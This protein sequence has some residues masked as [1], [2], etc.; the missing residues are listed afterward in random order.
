MADAVLS[1]LPAGLAARLTPEAAVRSIAV[2]GG[3][4]VFWNAVSYPSIQGYDAASHREYADWLVQHRSLPT[5]PHTPEYY[6][7]PLYYLLA[8]LADAVGRGVGLG[9]PWRLA[10]LLNV[11]AVVGTVLLVAAIARLVWPGRRWLAPVA[12]AFVVLSPVLTRTASMFHPET[13]DLFFSALGAYLALRML[14]RREY[15]LRAALV[16]G[17]ALG[18]GEMVRQFALYTLSVVAAAWLVAAWQRPQE[19]R[20]L[21]RA[22]AAALA[23][24]AVVAGP[25][26]VYRAVHYSNPLFNGVSPSTK[27]YFDR[28]PASFYLGSGLPDLFTKP[29][30]PNMADLAWPQTYADIWGD[31]YGVFS[32]SIQRGKPSPAAN[33]WLVLQNAVG[34]AP[35]AIALAGWLAL[36]GLAVRR[37]AGP[38]LLVALL[39]LA[40]LAGYFYFAI[41]YPTPDGDVLKPTFM[42][43]TLWAWALCFAWG[44]GKLAARAPRLAVAGLGLLALVDLPFVVYRGGVGLL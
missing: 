42:L 29:Y 25:W 2:A 1:R 18:A 39:P 5:L 14:L 35:T 27:P 31:W 17:V 15:G 8:G 3:L 12:A 6:S 33:R 44:A 28:R 16:L 23:A 43:S 13:T 41:G 38:L 11:P 34:I 9:D 37:R 36:L 40:G 19:R 7:P 24:C 26:Y 4:I 20:P 22:G 21:L 32:W 30:R 10:Q